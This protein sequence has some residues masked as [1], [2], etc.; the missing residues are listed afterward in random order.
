[1]PAFR[2]V[3]VTPTSRH[4]TEITPRPRDAVLIADPLLQIKRVPVVFLGFLIGAPIPCHGAKTVPGSGGADPIA[5]Q[6]EDRQRLAMS[7]LR[8]P[9]FSARAGNSSIEVVGAGRRGVRTSSS[10]RMS[11]TKFAAAIAAA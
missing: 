3:Y 10:P 2:L 9:I 6:F 1:M 5:L 8:D 7:R 4:Q 11:S